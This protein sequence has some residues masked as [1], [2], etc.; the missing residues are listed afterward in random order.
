MVCS[1]NVC[2]SADMIIINDSGKNSTLQIREFPEVKQEF[3]HMLI[4]KSLSL[5]SVIE[6]LWNVPLFL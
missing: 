2:N 4:V 6:G 3:K 5:K 1:E